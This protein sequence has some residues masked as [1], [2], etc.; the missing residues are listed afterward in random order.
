MILREI[1]LSPNNQSFTL[2]LKLRSDK[3]FTT[4]NTFT[5]CNWPLNAEGI[6]EVIVESNPISMFVALKKNGIYSFT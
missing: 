1:R 4:N 3:P 5:T 2:M 6:C